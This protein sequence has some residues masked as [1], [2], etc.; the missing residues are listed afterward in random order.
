MRSCSQH[1]TGPSSLNDP[2]DHPSALPGWFSSRIDSIGRAGNYELHGARV[3]ITPR[4]L[5]WPFAADTVR[6]SR[7]VLKKRVCHGS[8]IVKK[9]T[10][11]SLGYLCQTTM[12]RRLGFDNRWWF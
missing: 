7:V 11:P 4:P 12:R 8:N 10:S 9:N 2:R 5:D 3:G 1:E 6:A